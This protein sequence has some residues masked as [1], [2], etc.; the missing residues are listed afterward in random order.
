MVSMTIRALINKKKRMILIMTYSGLAIFLI[1][2]FFGIQSNTFPMIGMAGFG[3]AF[4]ALVY[5]FFGGR[6]HQR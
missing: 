2:I 6:C 3:V 5:A 4:I 1:G